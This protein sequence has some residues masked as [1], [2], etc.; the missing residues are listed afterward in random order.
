MGIEI[1]RKFLV[2]EKQWRLLPKPAG[3]SIKQ[4][5]ILNTANKTIRIRI[6]GKHAYITFK[7]AASGI[8]RSEYEY[9]IPYND[10]LKMF[11]EF[12]TTSIEKIRY[13]LI[14]ENKQWEVDEFLG[15]NKGLIVAE[16]ELY[17]E[18]EEFITPPWITEQ[19]TGLE[20][21]YNASLSA[22]PYKNWP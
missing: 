22:N 21:Y 2:D 12:V 10:G 17:Y 8:S 16:V 18:D 6:T 1:E 7:G 20:Q 11:D 3:V 13:C 4:G 5:Y 19:V 9:E 15:D 14:F